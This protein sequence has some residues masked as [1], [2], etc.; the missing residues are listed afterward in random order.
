MTDH[1]IVT[2]QYFEHAEP[3][4][5]GEAPA[6]AIVNGP[7]PIAGRGA[8]ELAVLHRP[9]ADAVAAALEKEARAVNLAGDC[10]AAVPA[11]AGC[12]RAGLAPHIV[13]VDAHADFNTPE[14]SPSQFLGGMPLAMMVGRGPQWMM[15]AVGA[16]PAPEAS[17]TLVDGRDLD[18]LEA[19]AVAN[20]ALSHIETVALGALKLDGPVLL[21]IDLD[22]LDAT[23]APA[24]NYPVPGGPD[25][26]ELAA[27]LSAFRA[28]NDIRCISLSAWSPS[29]DA[30]GRTGA[31]CRQALKPLFA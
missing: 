15:D 5:V 27:A 16:K 18:P 8:A 12:Q 9:V 22:V 21:H 2:P 6:A 3:D 13:W 20:S 11:L 30:D 24:F 1:W 14:T 7:H 23:A 19:E 17:V 26:A 25:A 29:K 28:A 10:C 4:L 31:A